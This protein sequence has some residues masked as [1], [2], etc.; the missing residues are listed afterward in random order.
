VRA[1]FFSGTDE[2]SDWEM[3]VVVMTRL[4]FGMD[5]D[6]IAQRIKIMNCGKI[7]K[8]IADE[9]YE[10]ECR[11]LYLSMDYFSSEYRPFIMY[12]RMDS[13]ISTA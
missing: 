8:L 3:L 9:I 13:A 6:I 4:S 7:Y 11:S 1:S 12:T 5:K 10:F 2:R